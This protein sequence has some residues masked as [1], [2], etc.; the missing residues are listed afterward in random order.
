V[1]AGGREEDFGDT[2]HLFEERL[3]SLGEE[4]IAGGM[5]TLDR[6]GDVAELRTHEGRPVEGDSVGRHGSDR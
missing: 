6:L 5:T 1:G 4:T 3:A 2:E